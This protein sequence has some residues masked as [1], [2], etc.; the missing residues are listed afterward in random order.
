MGDKRAGEFFFKG[1]FHYK[2]DTLLL[3]AAVPAK[4]IKPASLNACFIKWREPLCPRLTLSFDGKTIRSAE[5]MDRY[6]KPLHIVSGQLAELGITLGQKTITDKS[7]EI[8][9]V[10]ELIGLLSI[11]GCIIV[12]DALNC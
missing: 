12:A 2:S 10:R 4:L 8:P 3:P 7:N 5:R 9:A 11:E 1:A 6:D